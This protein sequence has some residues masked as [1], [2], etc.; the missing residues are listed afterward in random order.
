MCEDSASQAAPECKQSPTLPASGLY[1]CKLSLLAVSKCGR[2]FSSFYCLRPTCSI[3]AVITALLLLL[4]GV[5]FNPGPVTST[6]HPIAFGSLNVCSAIG[7]MALIHQTILDSDLHVLAVCE[8]WIY[9]DTPNTI[10]RDLA[11]VGLRVYHVHRQSASG[12]AHCRDPAIVHRKELTVRPRSS[13]QTFLT[14]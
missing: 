9:E 13:K 1:I 3:H 8:S 12:Q 7:K 11:S 5:K 2:R 10:K 14:F 6:H 4:G